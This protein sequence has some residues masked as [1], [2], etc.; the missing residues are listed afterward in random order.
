MTRRLAPQ[1]SPVEVETVVPSATT[2]PGA[3]PRP[4]ADRQVDELAGEGPSST[5]AI[6]GRAESHYFR[7]VARLGVQAAD[8]LAYAHRHGVVHRDIKPAN[9]LLDLQGTALGYRLRPGQGGG[10]DDLTSP[11]DVVGTLRYMAPERFQGKA[12]PRCDV[13]SLGVTLYEMLTL[14]PASR[15][16]RRATY[17]C[18]PPRGT[19]GPAS[20]TAR[21]RATWRRSSSKPSR[22]TRPI[23]SRMRASWPG[24]WAGSSKAARSDRGRLSIPERLWRWSRRNRR[25]ALLILLAAIL[26]SLLVIG[27]TAAAWKFRE[28]RNAV[29]SEQLKT[30]A[31]LGRADWSSRPGPC[32][33]RD[34]LGAGPTHSRA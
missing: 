22:R 27:S 17:P 24:N 12:D 32:D 6:L 29:Q 1:P 11:G 7:N 9:L 19:V 4:Q 5:S 25:V 14:K 30:Q 28:Q 18:D 15:P 33:T 34:S 21:S 10:T 2:P 16:H 3:S 31:E 8:A 13:Y 20:T 23:A 26:T